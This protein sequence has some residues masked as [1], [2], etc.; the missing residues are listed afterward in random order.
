MFSKS[1]FAR[2]AFPAEN[3]FPVLSYPGSQ[4]NG[5]WKI[6]KAPGIFHLQKT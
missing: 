6:E 2:R 1:L 3:V 4:K 5:E